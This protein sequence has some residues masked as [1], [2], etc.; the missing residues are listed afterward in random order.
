MLGD[1][2]SADFARSEAVETSQCHLK[3]VQ[4]SGR[5]RRTYKC[6]RARTS[7]TQSDASTT[8]RQ[9]SITRQKGSLYNHEG[10]YKSSPT[11]CD[12]E[13]ENWCQFD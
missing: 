10:Q 9:S 7:G 13:H 1:T 6:V 5:P 4:A 11:S 12:A 8:A 2:P 3:V